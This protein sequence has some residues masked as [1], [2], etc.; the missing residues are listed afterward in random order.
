MKNYGTH[1]K[2]HAIFANE[3]MK[4]QEF[5]K[6]A[7]ISRMAQSIYTPLKFFHHFWCTR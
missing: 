3:L 1:S 6:Q 2:C 4:K 5:L 7:Y